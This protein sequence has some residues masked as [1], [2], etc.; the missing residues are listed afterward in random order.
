MFLLVAGEDSTG[1]A[2]R[3]LLSGRSAG[4]G[5]GP[6]A[7]VGVFGRLGVERDERAVGDA[8]DVLDRAPRAGASAPRG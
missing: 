1:R 5:R 3:G 8:L 2:A 7:E 6:A 4:D